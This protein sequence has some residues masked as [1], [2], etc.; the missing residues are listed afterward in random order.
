[1]I[2]WDDY[3]KTYSVSKAE[4][5]LILERNKILNKYLDQI[6]KPVKKVIEIGCG[7]GSNIHLIKE[8]RSDVECHALDNSQ[9]SVDLVKKKIDEAYHGDCRATGLPDESYDLIFSAGL[10]EHFKDETALIK[11]WKRLL[12]PKG[13]LITF[14]PARYSLW[15]LYQLLHLGQW[16]HGYEKAYSAK[17]LTELHKRNNLNVI[18]NTGIDPFSINGFLMKLLNISFDP[19]WKKSF[20]PSGYTEFGIVLNK[21][22]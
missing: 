21:K 15:Q 13:F 4:K 12:S 17:G 8:S 1:M 16:Q 5:W 10:M 6:D 14:V 11:E 18:E 20:L 9:I 2:H 22:S 7:F 3:W 19:I